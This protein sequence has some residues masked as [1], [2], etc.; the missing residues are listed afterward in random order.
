[1]MDGIALK[2]A[3]NAGLFPSVQIVRQLRAAGL[4]VLGSGLT[5]PDLSLAAATQ[6]Y[7]WAG[8]THPCA[9]NG[10]QFLADSLAGQT[11]AP[12]ADQLAVPSAPGLG[13]TLD[14][15]AEACLETVARR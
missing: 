9:L 13:L 7:A 1:M 12:L 3:R 15:R 10:P 11:L 14:A 8:I 6:L 5:D 2:P 4:M